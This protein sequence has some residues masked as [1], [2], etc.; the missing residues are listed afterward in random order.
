MHSKRSCEICIRS[1]ILGQLECFPNYKNFSIQSYF[2]EKF[3]CEGDKFSD[4]FLHHIFESENFRFS[5][6][7][8][9][10]LTWG[11][12]C[13]KN[14]TPEI[15]GNSLHVFRFKNCASY[16]LNGLLDKLETSRQLST[17]LNGHFIENSRWV[18]LIGTFHPDKRTLLPT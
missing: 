10:S 18:P 13:I 2:P 17:S 1:V 14:C 16:Q 11:G 6:C 8:K 9:Y 15:V 5:F 4:S 7:T 3:G 12:K